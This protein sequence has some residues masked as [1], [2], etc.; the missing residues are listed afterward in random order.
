MNRLM[1]TLLLTLFILLAGTNVSAQLTGTKSIPSLDFLTVA[2]AVTALNTNGVGA[3]GVVFNIDAGHTEQL[4]GPIILTATGTLANPIEFKKFG[5]GANPKLTSHAGTST[6]LDGMFIFRGSDYVTID[7]LDLE[8]N[9]S[10]TTTTTTMEWGYAFVKQNATA[11][12]NGC[13]NNVIKNCK[14]NLSTA[15]NGNTYA[16]YMGNHVFNATTALTLTAVGDANSFNKFFSNTITAYNGFRLAGFAAP[17]PYTL[18]DQNNEIGVDGANTILNH[19]GGS[20]AAHGGLWIAGQNNLYF[21]NNSIN[22][23]S[24]TTAA[25]NGIT[26]TASINS[27]LYIENNTIDITSNGTTTLVYGIQIMTGLT[28]GTTNTVLIKNNT[29]RINRALATSGATQFINSGNNYPF[30]LI[31]E[32]NDLGGTGSSLSGTGIIYG[33]FNGSSVVNSIFRNNTIRNITRA[34]TSSTS[35]F[36]A[37]SNTASNSASPSNQ[38]YGN[39]IYNLTGMG[40]SGAVGGINTSTSSSPTEIYNNKIYNLTSATATGPV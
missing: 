5:I 32:D 28:T 25:H 35:M 36:Y 27:N 3:G 8:E 16:I 7:G 40:G 39:I 4:S 12:F 31:I 11:P 30:Q 23:G 6:T 18:Y 9:A 2:A 37:I 1:T 29:I 13:Q 24:G 21:K 10:N 15:I 20:V 38:I 17:S 33:F 34:S 14:I 19:G 22:G 26:L